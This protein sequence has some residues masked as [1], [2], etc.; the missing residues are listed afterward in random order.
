MDRI[1]NLLK[2]NKWQII[3]SILTILITSF[4]VLIPLLARNGITGHDSAYH[5]SFI[6]SVYES[7]KQGTFGSRI[8]EQIGQDYGYGSGLFYS[9]IPAS[10]CAL[11]MYIFNFN[12]I[13]SLV[14]E[15]MAILFLSGI[16]V[17]FFGKKIFNNNYKALAMAILYI[18]FPYTLINIY[19]RFA[20]SEMFITLA[21]PLIAYGIYELLIDDNYK[22]FMLNFTLGY[23]LAIMTH[24]SLT[25]YITIICAIFIILNWKKFISNYKWFTF[26]VSCGIVILISC[27][28]YLPMLINKSIVPMTEVGRGGLTLWD[29]SV[30]I[31]YENYLSISAILMLVGYSLCLYHYLK[32][33]K[34]ERSEKQTIF[35]KVFTVSA[36]LNTGLFPWFLIWIKPFTMIQFAWRLF[37]INGLFSIISLVCY[38]PKFSI[39]AFKKYSVFI[40]VFLLITNFYMSI[41][42]L[43][44]SDIYTQQFMSLNCYLST[45]YG[46]GGEKNG[47]YFVKGLDRDYLKDRGTDKLIVSNNCQVI[48]LTNIQNEN[49]L[50]FVLSSTVNDN[51]SIVLNIPYSLNQDLKIYQYNCHTWSGRTEKELTTSEVIENGQSLLAINCKSTD[52]AHIVINYSNAPEFKKYLQD[53]PFEFVVKSG[54]ASFS[55][56]IKTNSHTYSVETVVSDE[57]TIELPTFAYK[58]YKVTLT[59]ENGTKELNSVLGEH[60]FLEITTSESGTI[61]VEFV[62]TYV[63]VA[64]IISIV[65]IAIFVLVMIVILFVPRKFFTS[66]GNK[67]TKLFKDKPVLG[68]IV[69]FIIVGGIATVVDFLC[70]GLLMYLMQKDIYSSFINVFINAPTPST[71]ATIL[72]TSFGFVCG[73]I[74]NYI[75]SI[76]F[77]FNEKG[78]SKSTKGFII[79]TVLSVIGLGI[80]ILGTFIG[81][82]LLHINQWLVKIIMTIIVLI[83]NYISKKLVLFKKKTTP[84][85]IDTNSQTIENINDNTESKETLVTQN[86]D[87]LDDVSSTSSVDN[88]ETKSQK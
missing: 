2:Q 62:G 31:F 61:S 38:I 50:S 86:Q 49:I 85:L 58:G 88:N 82:D 70:M 39:K 8:F 87:N 69:R 43:V 25:V 9:M 7:L 78:N 28:Y 5:I 46:T 6:R 56:F 66:L 32:T 83:Y 37:A 59:N 20:F 26:L 29:T 33:P 81:F 19:V 24:L 80:N 13:T 27:A 21:F 57:T 75:L 68:E 44:T 84:M 76:L 52:E 35:F 42:F 48:E 18:C 15:I 73:L 72:G 36:V 34:Q 40:L 14:I 45:D 63:K 1:K 67:V 64:N 3:L 12:L 77:V 30:S 71:L 53:N 54:N 55:N 11:M 65:G 47:D 4:V 17:F 74:V 23:S 51:D 60:G 22:L 10:I 79:F 41:R 16:V